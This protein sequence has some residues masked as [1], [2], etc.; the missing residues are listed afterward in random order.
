MSGYKLATYKGANGARAG[1][2]VGENIIDAEELTAG[3]RCTRTRV[4]LAS[5]EPHTTVFA[6]DTTRG[7]PPRQTHIDSRKYRNGSGKPW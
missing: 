7:A 1:I 3:N 2:I 6:R 4:E 5:I